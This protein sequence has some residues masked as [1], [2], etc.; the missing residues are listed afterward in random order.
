MLATLRVRQSI[1]RH[2]LHPIS[3]PFST[4]S[5]NHIPPSAMPPKQK[6]KPA[7]PGP[8]VIAWYR[9]DLRLHDSPMLH[10]ALDL[11]PSVLFPIWTW[12]PHYVYRARVGPNR[13]K[14]LLDC[15]TD[16][17]AS[18]TKLNPRQKLHVLREAPQ[19]VL[20][21]IFRD[22]KIDYLVFE[23]DTDAYARARDEQVMHVAAECG[24][25]V[26]TRSGRTLWDADELVKAN[27]GK[28]TM[29]A[30]Q[31]EHAGQKCGA[32]AEPLDAPTSLPDPDDLG[33]WIR[34]TKNDQPAADPDVNARYRTGSET[35]Y[36]K[37]IAGPNDD[38]APPTMEELGLEV[39]TTPH[40]GGETVAL[41]IVRRVCA[42]KEY[43]ATF[44]KP[45]TAPTAFEPQATC[46]TSPHL[47]FGSL[48]VR[49]FWYE[50][51]KVL[52]GYK[53]AASQPPV[54]LQGQ[55]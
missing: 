52:D 38:F 40:R 3:Q 19:T 55:L 30:T 17:S 51:Q 36:A 32:I 21:K 53:G 46:L 7:Q 33:D 44:E 18:L 22:W 23:R 2:A 39:A 13:W 49:Y 29:S 1:H 9:T 4:N 26:I 14:F 54:S 28:P 5:I 45:K 41:D 27:G 31:V 34:K 20:G 50:I 43:C 8:R 47:H 48:S 16:L 6:A 42:D 15:Q 37:G 24:V 35:S 25:K 12:D 10:A 11:Q